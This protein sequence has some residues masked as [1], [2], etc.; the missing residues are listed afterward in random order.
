MSDDQTFISTS[1]PD[2]APE[3]LG[4]CRLLKALGSGGMGSVYLAEMIEERPYAR[5]GERVA[6]K[7]LNS[8]LLREP[9]A[10]TRFER[11]GQLG[12][13]VHHPGVVRTYEV[14]SDESIDG[15]FWFL[16]KKTH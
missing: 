10:V 5:V 14:A 13:E 1:G 15:T 3:R 11:E 6:I 12:A 9:E 16:I 8:N 4:P 7:V 2:K